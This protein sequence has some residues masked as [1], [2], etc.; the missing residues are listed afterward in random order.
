MHSFI[1]SLKMQHYPSVLCRKCV[2]VLLFLNQ[3]HC[4]TIDHY[5]VKGTWTMAINMS[6]IKARR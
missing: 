4:K 3:C 2:S 5:S 6:F 1:S